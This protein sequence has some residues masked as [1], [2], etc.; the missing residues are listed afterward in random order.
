MESNDSMCRREL[1]TRAWVLG[2]GWV[3]ISFAG[4]SLLTLTGCAQPRKAKQHP[5]PPPNTPLR[6]MLDRRFQLVSSSPWDGT[7]KSHAVGTFVNEL[8]DPQG[9]QHAVRLYYVEEQRGYYDPDKGVDTFD[10]PSTWTKFEWQ[11][12]GGQFPAELL[13]KR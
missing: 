2:V 13:I 10:L 9:G 4:G 3:A 5:L 11:D 7:T 12:A 8:L 1:L 6:V